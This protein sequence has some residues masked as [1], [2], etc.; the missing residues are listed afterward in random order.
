MAQI[1]FGGGMTEAL[2]YKKSYKTENLQFRP[3]NEMGV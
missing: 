3:L 2:S 1:F